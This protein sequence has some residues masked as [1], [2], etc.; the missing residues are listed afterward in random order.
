MRSI[1]ERPQAPAALRRLVNLHDR[2]RF[3]F[4]ERLFQPLARLGVGRVALHINDARRHRFLAERQAEGEGQDQREAVNPEQ[5]RRLAVELAETGQRQLPQRM[6]GSILH[7]ARFD[8]I[9]VGGDGINAWCVP[10][11]KAIRTD[12]LY[13]YRRQKELVARVNGAASYCSENIGYRVCIAWNELLSDR[14]TSHNA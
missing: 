4:H 9:L 13:P 12:L 2:S 10:A 7:A 11:F 14:V 5:R 8:T 3:G 1:F 6:H